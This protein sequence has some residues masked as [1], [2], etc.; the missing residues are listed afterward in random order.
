MRDRMHFRQWKRR[1]CGAAGGAA[2]T[3]RRGKCPTYRAGCVKRA[4]LLDNADGRADSRGAGWNG[5]SGR[6][7]NGPAIRVWGQYHSRILDRWA[8]N[9]GRFEG[10]TAEKAVPFPCAA[11]RSVVL[12]LAE[13]TCTAEALVAAKARLIARCTD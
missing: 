11:R 5:K 10:A 13:L 2:S 7:V 1:G 6:N 4:R 9:T 12:R 3:S 8:A